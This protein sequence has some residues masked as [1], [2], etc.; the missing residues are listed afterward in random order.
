MTIINIVFKIVISSGPL[1]RQDTGFTST[2][3]ISCY[4]GHRLTYNTFD[5]I[6]IILLFLDKYSLISWS[7]WQQRKFIPKPLVLKDNLYNYT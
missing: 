6:G 5:E 1:F 2:F 4:T 3:N 7:P